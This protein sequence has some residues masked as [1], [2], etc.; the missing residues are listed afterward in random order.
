MIDSNGP[1]ARRFPLVARPRPACTPLPQ[2]VIHLRRRAATA[3]RKHD[4]AEATAVFNL[5]ALLASDSG[6][7]NL[8][9]QWTH[10]LAHA[11]LR[12]E[13]QNARTAINSLEPVVNLARLRTR[14]GD[15]LGA[16]ALLENLYQ[17]TVTRT[18]TVIDGIEIPAARLTAV[19]DVYQQLR[20]WLWSVLLSS[21]ARALAVAGRWEDAHRR[22]ARYKGI[23]QRMLDGRQIAVM[24]H[25]STS[26]H[27][28]VLALLRD[29]QPGER[30]ENAVTACLAELCL[31]NGA[32]SADFSD[33]L[34]AYR[35]LDTAAPGLAVFHTRLGLSLIDACG[36]VNKPAVHAVAATL[37]DHAITDG[38]A[39]RDV[40]AH[41]VCQTIATGQQLHKL[42]RL[43]EDCGLDIGFVS[44]DVVTELSAALNTAERV[45][46]TK[47]P[48]S[49]ALS[50]RVYTS[51]LPRRSAKGIHRAW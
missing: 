6:L 51:V 7:P 18:D 13:S 36:G 42:A 1:T 26:E 37:L 9:H 47:V 17:A 19:A 39:A 27:D 5:A 44:A 8:A 45:I 38:Y 32:S 24:A 10:R 35:A 11:T 40:L 49:A 28:A 31:P 16:W 14:A 33:S 20:A 30:W 12:R 50:P 25:A 21:G 2:R 34:D 43:V 23:G 4:I 15:G 48:A 46:S 22:L 41:P 3:A 29:T